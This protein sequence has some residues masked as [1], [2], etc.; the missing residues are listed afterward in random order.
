MK[1]EGFQVVSQKLFKISLTFLLWA[2]LNSAGM[3]QEIKQFSGQLVQKPWSKTG[4]SYC[5]Q[6]SDYWVLVSEQG[7][8]YVLAF[9]K[10]L[11]ISKHID[12]FV[13]IEGYMKE[14]R[15]EFNDKV[16]NQHP[17][18]YNPINGQ[19]EN[20]YTCEVLVVIKIL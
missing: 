13:T 14:K 12:K 3:A 20:T 2:G 9:D 17:I 1:L 7:E 4:Q 5:A 15:I 18:S 11:K 10:K 8:E 6:G 16:P 19:V